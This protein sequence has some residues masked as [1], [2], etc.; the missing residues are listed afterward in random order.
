MEETQSLDTLLTE[1]DQQL[2]AG[3]KARALE[4]FQFAS[5]LDPKNARAWFG[6]AKAT[7]SRDEAI[8]ALGEVLTLDPQ[9]AEAR[10]LRLS[11]QVSSLRD[12]INAEPEEQPFRRWIIPTL[13]ALVIVV[14]SV[15]AWLGRDYILQWINQ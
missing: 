11:L 7:T 8:D 4:R 13:L 10:N 5:K 15:A 12:G 9:N 2:A 14:W 1:G 6:V 3:D